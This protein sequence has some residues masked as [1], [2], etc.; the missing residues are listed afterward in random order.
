MYYRNSQAA[1]VVYDIQNRDSFHRAKCW[2]TTL[3]NQVI[4]LLLQF[5]LNSFVMCIHFIH[6]PKESTD[7]RH[8]IGR[9]QM[10]TV[11]MS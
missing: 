8:C 5:I 9:K 7:Q 2:V 4:F 3:R 6:L 11:E 1:I 10:R